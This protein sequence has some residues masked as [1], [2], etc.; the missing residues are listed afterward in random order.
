MEQEYD[1]I[2]VMQIQSPI[3]IHRPNRYKGK[4]L[5]SIGQDYDVIIG[6]ILVSLFFTNHQPID[7]SMSHHL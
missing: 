5:Q 6:T 2:I 4:G 1:V 3:E 7:I